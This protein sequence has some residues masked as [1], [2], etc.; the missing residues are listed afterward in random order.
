MNSNPQTLIKNIIL[1]IS[2]DTVTNL[3]NQLILL[4]HEAEDFDTE[5]WAKL[6]LNG[7]F[8]SNPVFQE[9]DEIP[10]YRFIA[11][12][13]Y[14][15]YGSPLIFDNPDLH[16]ITQ[17]PLR[18]PLPELENLINKDKS[19]AIVD[20]H[21]L[22]LLRDHLKVNVHQ[23]LFTPTTVIGVLSAIRTQILERTQKIKAKLSIINNDGQSESEFAL[24]GLHPRVINVAGKLFKD[25]YYRQALLDTYIALI[26]QVKAKSGRYDLD[27]TQLIQ[28]VLSPKNPKIVIGEDADERMGFMWLFSGAVMGIRNPKA[29][30]LSTGMNEDYQRTLELLGFASFLFRTL[31]DSSVSNN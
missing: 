31:D 14:D 25:G 30:R 6:E 7:Y 28:Q 27:G 15:V 4:A 3:M 9:Q 24:S 5:R 8:D 18:Q 19:L 23:F 12:Q 20:Q 16:F 26:E 21:A 17:Y 29:H 13:Y 2:S 11:G 22:K 10:K 1:N